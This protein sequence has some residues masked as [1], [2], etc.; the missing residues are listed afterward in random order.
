MNRTSIVCLLIAVAS[1]SFS[2]GQLVGEDAGAVQAAKVQSV[3]DA[4]AYQLLR[5]NGI[6][7]REIEDKLVD[8][9]NQERATCQ[10]VRELNTGFSPPSCVVSVTP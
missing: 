6:H 7:L 2:V 10:N 4:R 1:V 9:K 5:A 8:V 3:R